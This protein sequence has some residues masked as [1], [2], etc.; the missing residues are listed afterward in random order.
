ML[1]PPPLAVQPITLHPIV[2]A[3]RRN[4]TVANTT[5]SYY[6]TVSP[7]VQENPRP[8][9]TEVFR[10]FCRVSEGRDRKS[11][12]T[13]LGLAIAQRAVRSHDGTI[14]ARNAA[15]GG[16]IVEIDIPLRT[17]AENAGSSD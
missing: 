15:D 7:H 8:E 11:G 17:A 12:G 9:L 10:P 3:F 16:L 5:N 1:C 13:G 4:E 2:P 6:S 14:T